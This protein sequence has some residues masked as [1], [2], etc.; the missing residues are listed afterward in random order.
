MSG[1]GGGHEGGMAFCDDVVLCTVSQSEISLIRLRVE[2]PPSA[3]GFQTR[4]APGAGDAERVGLLPPDATRAHAPPI[5]ERLESGTMWLEACE[6][7]RRPR[8]GR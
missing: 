4:L 5:D 7:A 2:M 3:G 8:R 1:D 6:S